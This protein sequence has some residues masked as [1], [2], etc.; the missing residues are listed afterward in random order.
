PRPVSRSGVSESDLRSHPIPTSSAELEADAVL[1]EHG[2]VK[3]LHDVLHVR[4][5]GVEVLGGFS[6]D[7]VELGVVASLGLTGGSGDVGRVHTV[8]ALSEVS[9]VGVRTVLHGVEVSDGLRDLQALLSGEAELGGVV[10]GSVV[11]F[12][13]FRV[14]DVGGDVLGDISRAV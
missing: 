10:L 9:D 5:V 14:S 13:L 12:G 7:S 3:S 11:K 8:E 1:F 2:A 4:S 6:N